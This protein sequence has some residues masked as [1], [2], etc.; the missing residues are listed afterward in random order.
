M[1]IIPYLALKIKCKVKSSKL[2]VKGTNWVEM[3]LIRSTHSTWLRAGSAQDRFLM[4][5]GGFSLFFSVFCRKLDDFNVFSVV[6]CAAGG[7]QEEHLVLRSPAKDVV[8]IAVPI[9]RQHI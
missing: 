3:W 5:F 4:I 6:I 7:Q 2:K 1:C 9:R 8:S